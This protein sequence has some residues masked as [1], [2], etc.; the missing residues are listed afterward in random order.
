MLTNSGKYCNRR[1]ME[2]KGK[3]IFTFWLIHVASPRIKKAHT[4]KTQRSTDFI[5]DLLSLEGTTII[6]AYTNL[7]SV[8]V[9]VL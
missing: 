2:I 9:K 5:R 6:Q 1:K 7:L 8:L 4:Q 3:E